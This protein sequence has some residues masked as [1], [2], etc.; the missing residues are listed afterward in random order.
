IGLVYTPVM[1]RFLGQSEYG[2]YAL[3]GS[4]AAY[5]SVLD[6]GLGNSIVRYLSRNRVDKREELESKLIGTF[7]FLFSF[8]SVITIITGL[9]IT[10]NLD[11]IFSSTLSSEE[12][13]KGKIMVLILTANF[14]LSFPLSVFS[15]ILVAYER[16]SVEKSV[17]ILRILLAPLISLPFLMMGYGS[18]M[19]VLITTIVNIS[20]LLYV[21]I[22]AIRKLKISIR[23]TFVDK[24]VLLEIFGYSFFIFLNII[25]D[26]LFWKTDQVIL[27]VVSGTIT[28]AVYAIAMHFINIYKK[29][30]T[31]ISNLFLPKL[32]MMVANEATDKEISDVMIR[33]GRVQYI[34]IGLILSGFIIFGDFFIVKWAGEDY[35]FAYYFVLIIMIPLTVPL[36]QNIGIAI[37][38]A[39]NQIKFRAILYLIIAIINIIV[40]IPLAKIYG[41]FGT[42]FITAIT[43][44]IGHIIIMNI[45]YQKRVGI[46]IVKFWKNIMQLTVPNVIITTIT[47][48]ILTFIDISS[49]IEWLSYVLLFS[50][51]YLLT[52][53]FTAMNQYEKR[54]I[55]S[56]FDKIK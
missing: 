36:I 4:I 32:S 15:S 41:G 24:Q 21:M 19:L 33:Y 14:A 1:I 22:Y 39:K 12:I 10:F 56:I 44:I 3:I 26:Q 27:G 35:Y 50:L 28:V 48:Y 18:I 9:L 51:L 45:Y 8:V 11:N 55:T 25:I 23:L 49:I 20:T 43:M 42:A 17:A 46:N 7:L 37:L 40:S 2:L 47:Y 31:A 38:Q 5:F 53:W 16:F 6:L 30:S 54:L 34:L 13:Y 52:L 29:F